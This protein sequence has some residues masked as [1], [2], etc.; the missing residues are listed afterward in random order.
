MVVVF[1]L[2]NTYCRSSLF[3]FSH[4]ISLQTVL[5][6]M[7][8]HGCD[9]GRVNVFLGIF[10]RKITEALKKIIMIFKWLLGGR[11]IHITDQK[12]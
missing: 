4:F 1:S 6:E 5:I 8:D 11:I 10:F 7:Y 12:K 9:S 3:A 2:K